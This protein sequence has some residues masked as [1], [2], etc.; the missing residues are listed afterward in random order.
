MTLWSR[1]GWPDL[2]LGYFIIVLAFHAVHEVWEVREE[3]RLAAK[4]LAGEA[5]D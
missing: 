5:T 4:T 3:E 2:T 1:S